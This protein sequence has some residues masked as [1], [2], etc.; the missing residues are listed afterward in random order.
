MEND[1][2]SSFDAAEIEDIIVSEIRRLQAMNKGADFSLVPHATESKHG[3][4][5]SVL[6][7]HMKRMITKN[8]VE[9]VI[10]GGAECFRFIEQIIENKYHENPKRKVSNKKEKILE[11]RD[12]PNHRGSHFG[13]R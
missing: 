4:A 13:D 11:R 6:I 2:I 5:K 8:M 12:R 3:L 7:L 9:V 1:T 10:R